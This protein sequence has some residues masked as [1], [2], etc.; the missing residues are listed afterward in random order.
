MTRYA[1]SLKG[2]VRHESRATEIKELT[3]K[4]IIPY[5]VDMEKRPERS[6]E[7]RPFW[8]GEVSAMINDVLPAKVIVQNIVNDA[9]RI[10]QTNAAK[11]KVQAKL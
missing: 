3:S 2:G 7:A 4:G 6:L 9:A 8:L 11:V 1:C 5:D 10:L